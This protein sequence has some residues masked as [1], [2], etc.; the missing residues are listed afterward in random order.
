MK[1]FLLAALTGLA[2]SQNVI[3]NKP[4]FITS[5]PTYNKGPAID[6]KAINAKVDKINQERIAANPALNKGDILDKDALAKKYGDKLKE[7]IEKIQEQKKLKLLKA[8]QE[9]EKEEKLDEKKAVKD[10]DRNSID[11]KPLA[12]KPNKPNLEATLKDGKKKAEQALND[13][14]KKAGQALR[15]AK[16]NLGK[17]KGKGKGKNNKK[18]GKGKNGKNG[19]N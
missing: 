3:C 1:L 2:A 6:L 16:K 7:T 17:K 15:N 12:P 19:K 5:I 18:K 13:A 8:E 11:L 9:A 14:K 4:D 10:E